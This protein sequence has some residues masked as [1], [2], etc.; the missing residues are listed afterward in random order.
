MSLSAYENVIMSMYEDGHTDME[1]SYHLSELGMERGNSE[2]NIG[3]FH[4]EKGLKRKCISKDELE[5]VVSQAA[6]KG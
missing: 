2:Q 3:K 4:S 6:E 5:L 1:K